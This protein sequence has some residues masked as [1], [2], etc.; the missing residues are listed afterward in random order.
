MLLHFRNC[1]GHFFAEYSY[2]FI[3]S[4]SVDICMHAMYESVRR[5]EVECVWFMN[6][7]SMRG[8]ACPPR[9]EAIV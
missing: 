8:S 6:V 3:D 9:K 5:V 7:S 4:V 1:A 2:P